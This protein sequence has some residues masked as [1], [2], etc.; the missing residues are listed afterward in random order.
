MLKQPPDTPERQA[1]IAQL[2]A[3]YQEELQNSLTTGPQTL[4]QIELTAEIIGQHLKRTVL[5]ASLQ[6]MGSGE[7]EKKV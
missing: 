1:L 6:Q 7:G 5:E 4:D 3:A 2:V